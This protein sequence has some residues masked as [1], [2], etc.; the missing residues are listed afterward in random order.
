MT[1]MALVS[2][3]DTSFE[4]FLERRNRCRIALERAPTSARHRLIAVGLSLFP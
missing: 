1:S 3:G 4:R 2:S